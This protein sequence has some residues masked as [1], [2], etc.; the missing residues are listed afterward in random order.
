[1]GKT[2]TSIQI[3]G[4]L[5]P[6]VY[7]QIKGKQYVRTAP[8]RIK[9]PN[10][11]KQQRYKQQFALSS[12][13]ASALYQKGKGWFLESFDYSKRSF[14][15]LKKRIQETGM[16]ETESG[17]TYQFETLVITDGS[18]ATWRWKWE[19][20]RYSWEI[21]SNNQQ[22]WYMY[23]VGVQRDTLYVEMW[24]SSLDSGKMDV[25]FWEGWEYYAFYMVKKGDKMKLSRS[26]RLTYL[27]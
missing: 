18:L 24:S 16:I 3:S 15:Q 4:K 9:Y 13:L 26:V 21:S 25:P 19:S 12:S 22:N 20:N 1:M 8:N 10:T 2:E 27:E 5:G 23:V 7:Y 14:N 17:W 11:K 6:L